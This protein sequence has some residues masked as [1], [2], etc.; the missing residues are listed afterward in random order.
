VAA[1]V[2]GKDQADRLPNVGDK[3]QDMLVVAAAD[4]NEHL[5]IS[6]TNPVSFHRG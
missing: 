3:K 2:V 6:N 1:L 4:G 5:L